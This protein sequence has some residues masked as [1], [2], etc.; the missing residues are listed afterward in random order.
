MAKFD[1]FSKHK[2][3]IWQQL[4]DHIDADFFRGKWNKPDRIEAFHANWMITIDTFNSDKVI[5]TRIRAPYINR[6]D[7]TFRIFREHVGHKI[8]KAFGMKD[9]EV[10]YPAFDRDFVIQGSDERKLKMM[11]A[12]PQIRQ[13]ISFQPKIHLELKE[14]A[15]LFQKPKFPEDVNELYYHVVGIIKDLEQ[16]HDLYDLFAEALDHLCAIGT[17]YEDDPNFQYY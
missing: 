13:L 12:N 3:A 16:L 8:G 5:F 7:F 10:G 17:A 4:C 9:I 1:P 15:P 11:F 14:K 6:D 2:R